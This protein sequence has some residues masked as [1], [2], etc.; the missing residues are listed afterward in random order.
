M[1]ELPADPEYP[2][3]DHSATPR[4]GRGPRD[5]QLATAR[6]EDIVTTRRRFPAGA[7]AWRRPT[8]ARDAGGRH[9]RRCLMDRQGA[10]LRVRVRGVRGALR[11]AGRGFG[12]GGGLSRVRVGAD[13]AADLDGV[14]AGAAAARGGGAVGR[15][16]AAGEAKRRGRTGSASR[17]SGGRR[18]RSR[19]RGRRGERGA[20][21]WSRS[22][23]RSRTAPNA[24]C[25]RRGPRRSSGRAT[26]TPT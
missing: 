21:S 23:K 25:T 17:A 15:I 12:R 5:A 13:A 18:G 4:W 2:R 16:A 26:R 20:R 1:P 10:D 19:E 24:R 3:R 14:A 9:R 7:G 22:T 11:G 6:A 8:K